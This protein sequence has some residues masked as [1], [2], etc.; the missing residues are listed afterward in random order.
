[1]VKRLLD[2]GAEPE[3]AN[4]DHETALMLAIKTGNLD[5]VRMLMN[6]G[7]NVNNVETFHKQTPLMW[8][9]SSERNAGP[10]VALL[11]SKGADPKPRSLFTDWPSQISSEP[12]GQ[13]RPVGGLT[14]LLFAV[15]DGCF[16]CTESLIKAGADVNVPTPEGVTPLMMAI[17]NGHNEVAKLLLDNGAKPGVWDWWGR[18]A[19]YIAID[20]KTAGGGGRGGRGGA[21]PVAAR[22]AVSNMQLITMLLDKGVDPNAPMSITRP[23]RGGNSG[24]FG[25]NQQSTGCTPLFRAVQNNDLE[26]IRA[27]LDKGAD[28]TVNTM[29]FN[30]FLIAAGVGGGGRGGSGGAANRELLELL[31]AHGANA[32]AQVVDSQLY[33]HHVRYQNPPS[34]EG[35]SALHA[36]AQRGDAGMVQYLLDHGADPNLRDAQG[37][38]PVELIGTGGGAAA[39]KGKGAVGRGGA[40]GNAPAGNSEQIRQLLLSAPPAT[41]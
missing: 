30:P 28:P 26:V 3:G 15:R 2:A 5:T 21:A 40:P 8:A 19:L 31:M 7:A 9:A 29:G 20:R 1:M 32:N 38:R 25:E 13:F 39:A 33:S 37:R 35:S 4:A 14:A 41:R 16:E 27:L 23:S 10:M 17:D 12:R 11:L 34:Y 6:A 36:A 18:T 22:P 24:R